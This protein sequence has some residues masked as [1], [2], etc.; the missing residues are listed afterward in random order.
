[1][2]VALVGLAVV[3]PVEGLASAS[4]AEVWADR[5]AC[6]ADG[7]GAQVTQAARD[8]CGQS[9]VAAILPPTTPLPTTLPSAGRVIV[10]ITALPP[11][12]HLTLQHIDLPPPMIS[13]C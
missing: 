5:A 10:R 6:Q 4:V 2:P 7:L 3:M 11:T 8:F 12:L 9:G 13:D 1:M